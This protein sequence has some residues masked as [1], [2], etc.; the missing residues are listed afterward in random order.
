MTS[1]GVTDGRMNAKMMVNSWISKGERYY[2]C[3]FS[4]ITKSSTPSS[5]DNSHI[6]AVGLE[7]PASGRSEEV[8]AT[9]TNNNS[10]FLLSARE[11]MSDA[12]P[13]LAISKDETVALPNDAMVHLM[14]DRSGSVSYDYHE[15][16][17]QMQFYTEDFSRSL[18]SSEDPV[19]YLCK[20]QRTFNNWKVGLKLSSGAFR[21]YNLH[22]KGIFDR[23]KA[24]FLAGLLIF[25]DITEY[26]NIIKEQSEQNEQQFQ[27]VCDTLPQLLWTTDPQGNHD[28][29]SRRWYEYTGLTPE[30][31]LGEGW[32]YAFHPDDIENAKRKWQLSLD[33]GDP[34]CVEYRCK[35]HDGLWRYMLGLAAPLR[36]PR[37]GKLQKWFGSCT[38][39]EEL[40]AARQAAKST[41]ESLLNVIK[42]ANVTVWAVNQERKLTFL[43][44]KIMWD[45]NDHDITPASIGENVYEVFG[46]HRGRVDLHLYREP[47]ENIL[48]GHLVE[49]SREHH[50]DGNGRWFRTRFVPVT[51]Q[52]GSNRDKRLVVNG[53]IGI[54]MDVS[55]IKEREADLRSQEAENMSL[56]SAKTAAN[57]ASKL[58]SQ[59]L[60]NMS[61][62]IRTPIAGVIGMS[63][64]L[65]DTSLT[66][67]QMDF[68]QNIQRSANGLLTVIN[69]ILDLSKVE[70]G[71]LDIEEIQFSLT[72]V[73]QDVCK[74]LSYA[75]HRKELT[76]ETAV[77]LH[78]GKEVIVMG[79]PGR[80]RQILTN[81]LTNSIKFTTQGSVR[82]AVSIL[83]E[84]DATLSV[85]F[86]ITDTG[87]GIEEEIQKRLFKPFSQAD[88]S[89][90]RRFG[91]TGL[92]L[93]ICKHL[94]DLMGGSIS[95]ESA[96]ERGTKAA[97]S[98][99]F[100]KPQFIGTLP[101]IEGLGSLPERLKCELSVSGTSGGNRTG[102]DGAGGKDL[103]E[104]S[105]PNAANITPEVP[106]GAGSIDAFEA[107]R[108]NI[109]IM[110]VEDNA[111]N[112][113][114]ALRTVRKF[115]FSCFAVWNGQEALDYL[116][117]EPSELHP[118]PNII[119]MDCQMPILDGLSCTFII[120]NERPFVD[121]AALK[122]VPIVAMTASAIQGDRE[123]CEEAGMD[124][125]LAKPVKGKT[126]EQ[127]LE[128]WLSKKGKKTVAAPQ[129]NHRD[130]SPKEKVH[131]HGTIMSDVNVFR[132]AGT[133]DILSL[134]HAPDSKVPNPLDSLDSNG[135]TSS[136]SINPNHHESSENHQHGRSSEEKASSL[137]DDKLLAAADES[138]T[139]PD[140]THR[141]SSVGVSK[142]PREKPFTGGAALTQA[143]IEILD[144]GTNGDDSKTRALPKTTA[145]GEDADQPI[146]SNINSPRSSVAVG[147]D[148][149]TDSVQDTDDLEVQYPNGRRS[150]AQKKGH[151][152]KWGS[153]VTSTSRNE[154]LARNDSELTVTKE[155][156]TTEAS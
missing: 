144:H 113:Q 84:T 8:I 91:G 142:P 106:S 125:Y 18:R 138:D 53:V 122:D 73:L 33:T 3:M 93:T 100:N 60:A 118:L 28:W 153:T 88:P 120:R 128:K 62:E 96:L 6:A 50:I 127:M 104:L 135:A 65:L 13:M 47:I 131:G 43:E 12:V 85:E 66:A 58:K 95:L 98:V 111:I 101:P 29:F 10:D 82:L 46:R 9:P 79:D 134:A 124:D 146:D 107:D 94:V 74:M 35:R 24:R 145:S 92:G 31:C 39:I 4:D 75:A 143:N 38:D 69:D 148:S 61:H 15:L 109:H 67:D 19:A 87:I 42:H 114:I 110:V 90:A 51:H 149:T 115:G 34:Y 68:A 52:Q 63:E 137:R 139:R 129:T 112:Q 49:T 56:L 150:P 132:D 78:N 152:R 97:F 77:D 151:A 25:Q 103:A 16:M 154:G 89:T 141:K 57:E 86:V 117:Q 71:R 64:L 147:G 48:N 105:K 121:M 140:L 37:T 130:H 99:R 126:L 70:S 11:A 14:R 1:N 81:L 27:V 30:S 59:F 116:A 2:N 155:R 119:L 41:R 32:Q 133:S 80:V 7:Q 21:S 36:D 83:E 136:P 45:V 17:S 20:E 40:V 44:G 23:Q 22:G 55:E 26:R 5:L 76:F 54:S 156:Y 72:V 123:K 108:T 102:F